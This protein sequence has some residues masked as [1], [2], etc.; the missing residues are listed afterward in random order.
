M[1]PA[2]EYAGFADLR[3]LLDDMQKLD[4]KVTSLNQQGTS[5]VRRMDFLLGLCTDLARRVDASANV[6]A[7][8]ERKYHH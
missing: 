1:P 5:L 4:V 3:L 7:Q 2:D 8:H 6:S